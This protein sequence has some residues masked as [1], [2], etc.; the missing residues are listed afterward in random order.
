VRSILAKKPLEIPWAK[1]LE[2]IAPKQRIALDVGKFSENTYYG[3][4]AAMLRSVT[5][6]TARK[7][8]ST[9]NMA[10]KNFNALNIG[11]KTGSLDGND[12]NGRYEW[13]MG[14]AQ[15]KE[16]PKKAIIVVIM[17]VHDLQ[18]Y[19]SQ[20]ACQVAAMIMNYWAHQKLWQTN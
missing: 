5:N 10:R 19:R 9:K 18:G 12:P 3:L 14:F 15:S 11:G 6:G 17:Q 8:L 16:D 1:D 20:P 2:G 7:H 4:R 13:F